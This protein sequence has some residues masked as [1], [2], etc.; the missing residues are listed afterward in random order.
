MTQRVRVAEAFGWRPGTG[1][2]ADNY[3]ITGFDAGVRFWVRIDGIRHGWVNVPDSLDDGDFAR[4]LHYCN[5]MLA[6][7]QRERPETFE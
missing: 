2:D 5:E 4:A 7:Q 6:D 1:V 3:G